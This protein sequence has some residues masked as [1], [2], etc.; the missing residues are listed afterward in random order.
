MIFFF[1][2]YS[3][4][5][6][7]YGEVGGQR[8]YGPIEAA[9]YGAIGAI[10]RSL[11][12]SIDEFPHTGVTAFAENTETV[13][14]VAICT[15]DANV[16]NDWLWEDPN[17]EFSFTTHC[18]NKPDTIA[19]NVIGE[20]K[21]SEFPDQIITVGGHLD[22]WD[23]DPGAHDDGSGCM[24]AIDVLRIFKAL[25]IKPRHT[26]RAVMFMDEEI[27]QGGAKAYL[28]EA[29][30]GKIKHLAALESDRGAT[31]PLGFTFKGT[32]LQMDTLISYSKFFKPYDINIFKPGYGGVDINPLEEVGAVL[33]GYLPDPTHY[34][35]WHHC[36]NNTFDQINFEDFQKG[37]AAMA[38]LI[39]LIDKYG[40]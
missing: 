4:T 38:A 13:P 14:A 31:K 17:L 29:K 39:Y 36:A 11:T 18:K 22:S 6:K 5:F 8:F 30:E 23:I 24:Q 32:K 40:L 7:A 3:S 2:Q 10:I 34:F 33:I 35:D 9:K 20:I 21:G 12:T 19:Y 16:L 1:L 37:S 15:R 26:I 28:K 27:S 25:D